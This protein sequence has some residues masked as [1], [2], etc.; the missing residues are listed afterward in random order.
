MILVQDSQQSDSEPVQVRASIWG[1]VQG[2]FYRAWTKE[3]ADSLGLDGWVSNLPDGSVEAM[4]SGPSAS[5]DTML[6]L[7]RRGPKAAKVENVEVEPYKG[8]VKKGFEV[9][10]GKH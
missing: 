10:R 3:T 9:R 7:A 1:V 2:V 6:M 8:E 4:F 5:V